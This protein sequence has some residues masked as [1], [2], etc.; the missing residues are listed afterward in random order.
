MGRLHTQSSLEACCKKLKKP[1]NSGPRWL[2]RCFWV[3]EGPW[4]SGQAERPPEVLRTKAKRSGRQ[5][6]VQGE[7]GGSR[8]KRGGPSGWGWAGSVEMPGTL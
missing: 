3:G 6:K 7:G 4:K 8:G 5:G 2:Q 1:D